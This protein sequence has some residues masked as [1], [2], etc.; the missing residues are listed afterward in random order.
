M[1]QK[2]KL[3]LIAKETKRSKS[4]LAAAAIDRFIVEEAKIIEG[5]RA[6]LKDANAGRVTSHEVAMKTI[7]ATISQAE[8]RRARGQSFGRTG[9]LAH[10]NQQIDFIA[11]SSPKGARLVAERLHKAIENLVK[12]PSGRFGRVP[13]TDEK[14]A[15]K[16][17]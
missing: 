16:T 6:G 15:P 11:A 9:A 1:L 2:S 8:N 5:I 4:F 17:S 13:G 10:F 12:T 3:E 14:F 7:R